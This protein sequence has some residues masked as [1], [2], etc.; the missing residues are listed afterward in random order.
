MHSKILISFRVENQTAGEVVIDINGIRYQF[1]KSVLK[2]YYVDRGNY[3][4]YNYKRNRMMIVKQGYD[5]S[6]IEE[7]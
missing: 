4:A 1:A 7:T 6:G 2:H 3:K 5:M